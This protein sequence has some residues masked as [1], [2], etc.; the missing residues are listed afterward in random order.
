M[1]RWLSLHARK[2]SYW[3]F[4]GFMLELQS[5]GQRFTSFLNQ[6]QFS[7]AKMS[8][9]GW[10]AATTD[11][12]QDSV[13]LTW[14]SGCTCVRRGRGLST[15]DHWEGNTLHGDSMEMTRPNINRKASQPY[16]SGHCWDGL[17]LGF[18]LNKLYFFFTLFE[19]LLYQKRRTLKNLI[20][21]KPRWQVRLQRFISWN[22]VGNRP[23]A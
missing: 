7:N 19:C 22:F 6:Y 16:T 9:D 12:R 1:A 18:L 23:I 4:P 8:T 20:Y 17:T 2:H 5:S 15:K 14:C 3:P 21:M 10:H 13:S 11:G